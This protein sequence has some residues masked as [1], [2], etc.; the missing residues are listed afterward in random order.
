M[1]VRV[2][3]VLVTTRPVL[4][5]NFEMRGAPNDAADVSRVRFKNSFR[6]HYVAVLAF[7]LRRV[8]DRNAAEDLT[9]ETF[10]IAW[11]RRDRIPE[12]D[13]PWLYAIAIRVIANHLR[14][15]GRKA[16]LAQRVADAATTKG[17]ASSDPAELVAARSAFTEAFALGWTLHSLSVQQQ[18]CATQPS[19]DSA[20]TDAMERMRL[21]RA[22]SSRTRNAPLVQS[23]TEAASRASRHSQPTSRRTSCSASVRSEPRSQPPAPG[24]GSPSFRAWDRRRTRGPGGRRDAD[25][26]RRRPGWR[27]RAARVCGGRDQGRRGKSPTAGHGAGL[28]GDASEPVRARQRRHLLQRR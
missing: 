13:L 12:N 17:P 3:G 26:C 11:R 5:I 16:R 21:R 25:P 27:R 23:R 28:V 7:A 1:G 18:H 2:F 9:A 22:R 10:A 14:S 6:G 4:H 24:V 15:V 20:K 19:S 8:N